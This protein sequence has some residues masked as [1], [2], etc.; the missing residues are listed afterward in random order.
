MTATE[1]RGGFA[2]RISK[3][4][5]VLLAGVYILAGVMCWGQRSSEARGSLDVAILYNP[6]LTNVVSANRFTMQGGTIQVHGQ[7]FH[8]W[9][10]VADVSVLHTS[11]GG[12]SGTGLDLVTTTFGPRY[13]WARA[14]DRFSF[15]GQATVGE[16]NGINSVFPGQPAAGS[17]ANSIAYQAGGGV[18]VFLSRRVALRALD[19]EWLRTQLP[20]STTNVQNSL[21]LGAGVVF[22]SR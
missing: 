19:A 4:G 15:F 18:S 3:S 2:M 9:G 10:T 8:G 7:F 17:T 5:R 12:S 20:N 13:T 14:H 16:V 11:S 21:R 1:L 6:L 22:R